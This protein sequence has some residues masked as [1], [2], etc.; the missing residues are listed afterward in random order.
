MKN[1][2]F[3][4][5]LSIIS[6]VFLSAFSLQTLS[7]QPNQQGK[8]VQDSINKNAAIADSLK[9][10][11]NLSLNLHK[12]NAHASYYADKFNGRRTASG[13]KFDNSKF[14]AAHRKFP[15]GTMLKITNEANG[16]STIVEVTDRGPFTKGRE[17]DLSKKAFMEISANKSN[18]TMKVTIEK[19]E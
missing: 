15:F 12:K 9:L 7:L 5:I 3:I 2:R 11:S 4:L 8:T 19:I 10:V 6:V 17:I 13:R 14:T 16:K 1:K 18:G